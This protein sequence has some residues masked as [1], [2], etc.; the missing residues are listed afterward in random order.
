ML[1]SKNILNIALAEMDINEID[2][3]LDSNLIYY[4]TNKAVF[5]DHLSLLFEQYQSLGN[6]YLIVKESVCNSTDKCRNSGNN[7][8][9]LIGNN[10]GHYTFLMMNVVED[11]IVDISYCYFMNTKSQLDSKKELK[12]KIPF[13]LYS[14]YTL[15]LNKSNHYYK[16]KL[17]FENTLES[18][19]VIKEWELFC[20]RN[21]FQ[22]CPTCSPM[23]CICEHSWLIEQINKISIGIN[24]VLEFLKEPSQFKAMEEL[25]DDFN[26]V[27]YEDESQ[28]TLTALDN[29]KIKI[30]NHLLH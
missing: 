6:N 21:K 25:C 30:S 15:I 7:G 26:F 9:T 17:L 11:S 27:K 8:V 22:D 10:T 4:R 20:E 5:I 16:A 2:S 24:L 28:I 13:Y 12:F 23:L 3:I 1:S 19:H 29:L 18:I 14:D